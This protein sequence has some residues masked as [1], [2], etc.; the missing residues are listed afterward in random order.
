MKTR[1]YFLDN[2][3]TLFIFLVV[4]LHASLTYSH[5]MDSFWVVVDSNKAE[6]LSLVNMYLDLFIMFIIFYISGYFVPHS[7]ESKSTWRFVK[8]KF[9]RILLPWILASLTLVPAYKAVFL[10]SR[11]M[12]QEAWF[13]YF[14]FFERPGTD[15]TFYS[16]NPAQS[17]LW[18]LPVLFMFQMI[19]LGMKKAGLLSF[20]ISLR[21]AIV[22]TFVVSIIY[23]MVISLAGL[24]GWFHS[25]LLDFQRERLLIYFLSFLLGT[26]CHKLQMFETSLKNQRLFVWANVVVTLSL[27]IFTV[28]ALNFFF[29]LV[30]LGRNYFFV[31]SVADRLIYYSSAL[32]AMLSILYVFV[33][34]F[35]LHGNKNNKIMESLNRS[36]YNVYIIHMTVLSMLALALLK[37]E[38]PAIVKFFI[39]TLTTF[40]VSNVITLIYT[41][42][43][44]HRLRLRMATFVLL[45]GGLFTFIAFGNQ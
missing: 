5:G 35:Q 25:L 22:L 42:W 12:P 26:L 13:T 45:V 33:Y 9:R 17:W 23:S 8:V 1:V 27:T 31:S 10:H 19:Y 6:G 44:R 3:R 18:F 15:L 43:F 41:R 38:L 34:V 30:D 20:R 36:S 40:F 29:N 4:L 32:A 2:L 11:G 39:L 7:V 14:T 28:V 21:T 16:N 37:L 24:K